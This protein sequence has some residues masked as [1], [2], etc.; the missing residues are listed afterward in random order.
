MKKKTMSISTAARD[1][2]KIYQFSSQHLSK[3][4]ELTA[5]KYWN[6]GCELISRGLGRKVSS[7]KFSLPSVRPLIKTHCC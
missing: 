6:T 1:Y 3:I 5:N 4:I 2:S 7:Q